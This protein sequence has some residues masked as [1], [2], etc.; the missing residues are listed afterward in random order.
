MIIV[1]KRQTVMIAVLFS[2]F[3][4][5]SMSS[6]VFAQEKNWVEVAD[7]S[8][9][10]PFFGNTNCFTIEHSEWRIRWEYEKT[11]GNL[12]AFMFEVRVAETNQLIGNWNNSGKID[13]T[14]GVFNVTGYEGEFY[15]WIGT[16]GNYTVIVEQNLDALPEFSSLTILVSGFLASIIGSMAYRRRTQQVRKK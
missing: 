4:L 11:L 8:Q 3:L 2:L 10:R 13:I 9:N 12:T 1:E 7:F 16:N 6:V 5:V 15:L 14:Q